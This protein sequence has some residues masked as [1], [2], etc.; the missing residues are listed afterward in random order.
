MHPSTLDCTPF[1]GRK[2]MSRSCTD[3]APLL[4]SGCPMPLPYPMPT[5]AVHR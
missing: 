1:K 4:C 3:C 2:E 5:V